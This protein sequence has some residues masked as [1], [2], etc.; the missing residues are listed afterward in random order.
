MLIWDI[1]LYLPALLVSYLYIY[2]HKATGS[3]FSLRRIFGNIQCFWDRLARCLQIFFFFLFFWFF[4]FHL[5]PYWIRIILIF[6]VLYRNPN[7][8]ENWLFESK[9]GLAMQYMPWV[10]IEPLPHTQGVWSSAH[11]VKIMD[12]EK[13]S[14]FVIFYRIQGSTNTR[15]MPF[16]LL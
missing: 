11:D 16:L 5:N 2:S 10:S 14:R 4:E 8:N 13:V 3:I 12:Y 7:I 6:L 15:Q 9:T 1:R